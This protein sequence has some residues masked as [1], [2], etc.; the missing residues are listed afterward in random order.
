MMIE[1]ISTATYARTTHH[2]GASSRSTAS[3]RAR[4]RWAASARSAVP[5]PARSGGLGGA[6][7]RPAEA[8][9]SAAK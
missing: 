8:R 1:S 3:V 7:G 5:K 2:T 6:G 9:R 4:C